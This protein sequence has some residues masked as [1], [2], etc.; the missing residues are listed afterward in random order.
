MHVE[1]DADGDEKQPHQHIAERLD[2]LFHLQAEFR[3]GDQ[4]AGDKG[5]QRQR[6]ACQFG[7]GGHGQR[8]QQH[9]EDEY[10]GRFGARHQMKP[11]AHQFLA[12]HQNQGQHG[13]GLED[14]D[15]HQDGQFFRRLGQGR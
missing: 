5:A 4:H 6:Q 2:V 13:D 11:F 7:Q 9:V 8:D 10:L 3:F 15:A 14:C 1:F 12:K